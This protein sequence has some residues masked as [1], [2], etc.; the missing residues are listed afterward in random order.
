MK[1]CKH[2]GAT[3]TVEHLVIHAGHCVML[4]P[5]ALGGGQYWDTSAGGGMGRLGKITGP[6]G[7]TVGNGGGGS[8]AGG[9]GAGGGVGGNVAP[10]VGPLTDAQIIELAQ[11]TMK[12]SDHDES[13]SDEE[14]IRFARQIA[15]ATTVELRVDI[16]A[17]RAHRDQLHVQYKFLIDDLQHARGVLMQQNALIERIERL[18]PD[19][20]EIGAGMLASL[21][22][23]AKRIINPPS[24]E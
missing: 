18:N 13:P 9:S 24:P 4:Q 14:L 11:A 21:V 5:N 1:T 7:I 23:D 19:A 6:T 2:C 17:I 20:G 8:G 16:D 15:D 22:A 12:L 10:P 3:A